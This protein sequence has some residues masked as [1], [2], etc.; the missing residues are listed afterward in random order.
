MKKFLAALL[1]L[2]VILAFSTEVWGASYYPLNGEKADL[3][4]YRNF[5]GEKRGMELYGELIDAEK[6]PAPARLNDAASTAEYYTEVN[7]DGALFLFSNA[8]LTRD[9]V[10]IAIYYGYDMNND[11]V[12]SAKYYVYAAHPGTAQA[13]AITDANLVGVL[14][15]DKEQEIAD[16]LATEHWEDFYDGIGEPMTASVKLAQGTYDIY[17][18]VEVEEASGIS[19]KL[20][21]FIFYGTD[22]PDGAEQTDDS[23][24]DS[25]DDSIG[26]D[27]GD[28]TTEEE[29]PKTADVSAAAALLTAA[30]AALGGFRLGRKAIK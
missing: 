12:K 28:S 29:I 4:A 18:K 9:A 22:S 23:K 2:T 25:A 3:I 7:L 20:A 8:T 5:F 6:Y 14:G 19:A 13:D 26:N 1:C 15:Y 10:E 16:G 30:I 17:V 24:N 27:T 11:S 21:D